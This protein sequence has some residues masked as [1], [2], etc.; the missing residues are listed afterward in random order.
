MYILFC[1]LLN[2][3]IYVKI[4][5]KKKTSVEN[6]QLKCQTSTAVRPYN[7]QYVNMRIY[8]S[9]VVQ[10]YCTQNMFNVRQTNSVL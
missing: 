1:I 3:L 6:R 5:K 8:H 2:V 7:K 4:K 9:D 10:Y